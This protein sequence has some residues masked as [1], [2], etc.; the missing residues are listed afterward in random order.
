MRRA[1]RR[2]GAGKAEG[3]GAEVAVEVVRGAGRAASVQGGLDAD[4]EHDGERHGEATRAG[5]EVAVHCVPG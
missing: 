5:A 4:A 3:G 2:A 1:S